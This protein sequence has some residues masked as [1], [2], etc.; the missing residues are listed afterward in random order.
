[1]NTVRE[2]NARPPA[3]NTGV[4]PRRPA[5]FE[6]ARTTVVPPDSSAPESEPESESE[7]LGEA[8]PLQ[9]ARGS[10]GDLRHEEHLLRHLE[11]RDPTGDEI[12]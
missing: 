7:F 9:L 5:A 11:V 6:R 1:M 12:T 2:P 3:A 4:V 10:F 8:N